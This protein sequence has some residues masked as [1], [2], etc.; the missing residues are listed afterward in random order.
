MYDRR[1]EDLNLHY[2]DKYKCNTTVNRIKINQ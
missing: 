2:Q 1:F